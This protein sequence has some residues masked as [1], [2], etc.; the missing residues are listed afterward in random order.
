MSDDTT[1]LTSRS[2]TALIEIGTALHQLVKLKPDNAAAVQEQ[3]GQ[4]MQEQ[5]A[6]LESLQ[7]TLADA[8][9]LVGAVGAVESH[10][11]SK[12][13]LQVCSKLT[14]SYAVHSFYSMRQGPYG[15]S[16]GMQPGSV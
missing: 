4:Q 6:R 12:A 15:R 14:V 13:A 8:R 2:T 1:Q 7:W 3:A 10:G 9:R 11:P 16:R 5:Q